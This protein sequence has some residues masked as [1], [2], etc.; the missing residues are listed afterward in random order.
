MFNQLDERTL[1]PGNIESSTADFDLLC[2]L[3]DLVTLFHPSLSL[4]LYLCTVYSLYP[5][6]VPIPSRYF[7]P[8]KIFSCS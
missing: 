3:S 2:P 8:L 5:G 1:L 6:E 4:S 7:F